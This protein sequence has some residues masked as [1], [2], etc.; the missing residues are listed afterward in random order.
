M[1]VAVLSTFVLL[2]TTFAA[3]ADFS[4]T[5]TSK[6]T[7]GM[8]ASLGGGANNPPS[9]HY[10]KGQKMRTDSGDTSII[11]DFDAQTM[12]TISNRQKPISVR[13]FSI[14]AFE[15]SLTRHSRNQTGKSVT[16]P[17]WASNY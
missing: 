1:R 3:R 16:M 2:S 15:I 5:T 7:G 8:A 11:I 13:R 6:T 14:N 10:F 12:T 4:Y 9:K 17:E